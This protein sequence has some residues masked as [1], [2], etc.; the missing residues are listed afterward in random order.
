VITISIKLELS[1]VIFVPRDT[2]NRLAALGFRF[3]TRK[4]VILGTYSDAYKATAY[5]WLL[6]VYCSKIYSRLQ[7]FSLSLLSTHLLFTM[8]DAQLQAELAESKNEIQKLC[9]SMATPTLHKHLSL[10]SLVPKWSSLESAIP[11][12]EFFD[13]I[14]SPAQMVRWDEMD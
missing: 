2:T 10:I 13:T 12:E 1:R 6:T 4:I 3:T 8:T 14:L 7:F 9:L 11:L 5:S